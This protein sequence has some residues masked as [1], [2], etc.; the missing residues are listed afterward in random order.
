MMVVVYVCPDHGEAT[1]CDV[2]EY[3]QRVCVEC[4]QSVRAVEREA[5]A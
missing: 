3:G 1:T 4:G 2:D 5:S